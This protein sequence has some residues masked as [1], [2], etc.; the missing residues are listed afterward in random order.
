MPRSKLIILFCS[1]QNITES[2][3]VSDKKKVDKVIKVLEYTWTWIIVLVRTRKRKLSFMWPRSKNI[4]V[5]VY[6]T[7]IIRS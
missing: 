2:I 6:V 4:N 7:I 5:Q 3:R 1:P